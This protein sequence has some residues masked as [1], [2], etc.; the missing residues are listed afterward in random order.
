VSTSSQATIVRRTNDVAVHSNHSYLVKIQPGEGDITVFCFLFSG[1]FTR[2]FSSFIRL[3]PIV[4][5]NYTFYLVIARGTDG[6]SEPHRNVPEMAAAY[7]NEIR[8]VQPE[9]PY[10]ILGECFSAPVA[11]ETARQLDDAGEKIAMLGFLDARRRSD[12]VTRY[13]GTRLGARVR[14]HVACFSETA[15]G[16]YLLRVFPFHLQTFREL[17]GAARM[18]YLFGKIRKVI[19]RA[20]GPPVSPNGSNPRPVQCNQAETAKVKHLARAHNAY[21][22]AVRC[23][24]QQLWTGRIVVIANEEW[25]NADPTLGWIATEGIEVHRIPGTHQTYFRDHIRMV[26]DV[27]RSCIEKA[28]RTCERSHRRLE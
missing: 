14:H 16:N 21:A 18:S 6:I 25:C 28:A 19:T 17:Q 9:G 8:T 1:G 22:L 7:I 10:F 2:E 5:R 12:P 20:A 3:A 11:M 23:H 26:A 27:L 15:M 24:P 4:D 13:L